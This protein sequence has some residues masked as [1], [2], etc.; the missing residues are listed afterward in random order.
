MTC[1]W[2]QVNNNKL[3]EFVLGLNSSSLPWAYSVAYFIYIY[4]WL[5]SS[6]IFV[7]DRPIWSHHP[8]FQV[9]KNL[10]ADCPQFIPTA[11]MCAY[12]A[13]GLELLCLLFLI[14]F[15]FFFSGQP[16][17]ELLIQ[18]RKLCF[19]VCSDAQTRS[20][21]LTLFFFSSQVRDSVFRCH[22]PDVD[23]PLRWVAALHWESSSL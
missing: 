23:G 20:D 12:H 22:Q 1:D 14:S 13:C 9:D 6:H 15:F 7:T 2:Q 4:I 8:H 3:K 18:F 11:K 19:W 21:L 10:T 16:L 17:V 5:S